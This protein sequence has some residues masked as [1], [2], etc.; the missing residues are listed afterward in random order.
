[1]SVH[2]YEAGGG[3]K[4]IRCAQVGGYRL[5]FDRANKFSPADDVRT[6][7]YKN[8]HHRYTPPAIFSSVYE[9]RHPEY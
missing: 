7:A 1:M 2:V 5:R 6:R 9:I 3:G 8:N 4:L